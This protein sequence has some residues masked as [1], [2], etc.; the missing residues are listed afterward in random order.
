MKTIGLAIMA[1]AALALA[2]CGGGAT[3]TTTNS[4]AADPLSNLD[5][6]YGNASDLGGGT[7]SLSGTDAGNTLTGNSLSGNSSTGTSAT[8]NSA[9]ANSSAGAASNTLGN[10]N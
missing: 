8:G 10:S 3:N 2:G 7:N 9:A 4:L 5:A 6:G 1:T